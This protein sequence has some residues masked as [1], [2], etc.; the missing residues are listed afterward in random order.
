VCW[1]EIERPRV[2][3]S[4]APRR[5]TRD[6]GL[7]PWACLRY[8]L[9]AM[10]EDRPWGFIQLPQSRPTS[11]ISLLL[12]Y[13]IPWMV[14]DTNYLTSSAGLRLVL[15]GCFFPSCSL[16]E[17]PL[18]R[19][20]HIQGSLAYHKKLLEPRE[21]IS[22]GMLQTLRFLCSVSF[23]D[24]TNNISHFA[25]HIVTAWN[26]GQGIKQT[27]WWTKIIITSATRNLLLMFKQQSC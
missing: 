5:R 16:L 19:I 13:V 24:Y 15:F 11:H 10:G 20:I 4:N 6:H 7:T 25:R 27:K 12:A 8:K 18:K 14:I 3:F 9:P 1:T 22:I 2:L 21:A 26:E 23:K 17:K